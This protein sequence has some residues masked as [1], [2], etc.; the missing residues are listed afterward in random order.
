M[1]QRTILVCTP[2]SP[3]KPLSFILPIAS[4]GWIMLDCGVPK[5]GTVSFLHPLS[6]STPALPAWS[7]HRW[8]VTYGLLQALATSLVVP[9][10]NWV[11]K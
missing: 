7:T 9:A 2:K 3:P 10:A 11:S 5:S 1:R 6:L 4:L 8:L